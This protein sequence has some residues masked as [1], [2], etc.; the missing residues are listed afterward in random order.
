MFQQ[1]GRKSLLPILSYTPPRL[2]TGKEWYVGFYAY[3]PARNQMRRKKIKL[4]FIQKVAERRKYAAALMK[5]LNV[6][7]ENGW[8]PWIEAD[9]S[10][11]YHTMEDVFEQYRRF[12]DK[13]FADNIYRKDT[14]DSY[15]SYLRNIEEWNQSRTNRAT[16]IYQFDGTFVRMVLDHVYLERGNSPQT[17]DNYL[18]W[19][20]TFSTWLVQNQYVK[21]KPTD[22]FVTFGKKRIKKERKEIPQD[23]LQRI[24]KHV[25]K[26]NKHYLL[27]CY[28]LFYCFVRPKEMSQIRIEHISVSRQTL[29]IPGENSKNGKDATITLPVKVLKLMID[30]NVFNSPNS[31]FLFSDNFEPGK[32]GRSEKQFR[33]FWLNHVRNKLNLPAYYKFYSLKDTGITEMLRTHATIT[34]RDQARHSSLLTTDR[35]TPHDIQEANSMIKN[36][37][38]EF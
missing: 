10:R 11:A 20:R 32:N 31:Y 5:R 34:V 36:H 27:A 19:M 26:T 18:I 21:N 22:G 30:L 25:L 12:M 24:K 8:N 1:N 14:Y 13:M 33:D 17:R 38:G 2:Y 9:N 15:I 6:Q 7:L 23:V 37:Q 3:D 16:Y 4:N 35:Y 28:I 29:F